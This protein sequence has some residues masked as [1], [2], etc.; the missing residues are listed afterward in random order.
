MSNP[1]WKA[2]DMLRLLRHGG[3]ALCN[4]A[5][6]NACNAACA[7]CNFSRTKTKSKDWRWIDADRF[8]PALDILYQRDIRYLAFF[9]GEPLLHPRLSEMVAAAI[10]K[11]MGAL[12]IT[13]G[14]LL[15][16]QLNKLAAAGLKVM[17]ISIDAPAMARH[18]ANRGLKGLEERIREG[19]GA[20][21]ALGMSAFASVTMSKLIDD[22]RALVPLLRELG[23]R[24]VTFSYPQQTPH[25]STSL[26][27]S[28]DCELLDFTPAQLSQAFDQVDGLR[29]YF[30]VTNPSASI[31]DMKRHLR[32]ERE[33]FTCHGGYKSFYMD[34]NYDIW[35][36][37]AWNEPLCSVWDFANTPLV[38][39]GC[40][41]CIADCYR[42]SSVMLQFAVALGDS[43]DHLTQGRPLQAL[44]VLAARRN[45]T[46]LG[47]VIA[48]SR[49]M[50]RLAARG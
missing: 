50:P 22:Y 32:G 7:F 34:W 37:E 13:N 47:A 42:D 43:L 39:D 35:R 36:C 12:V 41:A 25:G 10:G 45:L 48:N 2:W 40:T 31:A 26:I 30:P 28:E 11:G 16:S 15:P 46:S 18:E 4:V 3:P 5:V 49:L 23:F 17:F 20:M 14:W 21:K 38:R 6:T 8:L 27:W 24:A 1:T 29:A 9:G 19:I 44:K 33:R